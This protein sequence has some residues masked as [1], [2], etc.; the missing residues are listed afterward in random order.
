[1]KKS[2]EGYVLCALSVMLVC[3]FVFSVYM[4]DDI[5][6]MSENDT[7]SAA[8]VAIRSFIDEN[9]AVAAFLG[10]DNG[11]AEENG[12]DISAEAAAYIARYNE[13]YAHLE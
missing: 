4:Y 11:G 13:I 12:A 5:A 2:F 9:E 8:A 10:I 6:A 1:M 7:L 3:V